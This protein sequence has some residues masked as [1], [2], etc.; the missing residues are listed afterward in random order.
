MT[1]TKGLLGYGIL[2]VFAMVFLAVRYNFQGAAVHNAAT[3]APPRPETHHP[4][5][6]DAYVMARRFVK[7][8]L[9][10]L[11]TAQFCSLEE[12]RLQSD[13]SGDTWTI[14]S[15]VDSQNRFSALVRTGFTVKIQYTGDDRWRLL[16]MVT[17]E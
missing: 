11:R 5:D 2:V 15:C 6:I 7:D 9:V 8:R 1:K 3:Y 12:S 4:L 17:D 10:A 14:T 16:S 13:G